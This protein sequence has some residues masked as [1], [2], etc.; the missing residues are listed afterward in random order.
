MRCFQAVFR[1]FREFP[2]FFRAFFDVFIITFKYQ[3]YVVCHM[4]SC[5]CLTLTTTVGKGIITYQTK[6]KR[7]FMFLGIE[8][9]YIIIVYLL[10][11][12]GALWCF[13]YGLKHWN[14]TD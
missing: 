8:D 1:P 4:L 14:D 5:Y 12:F 11:F 7:H 13:L 6:K 2:V 9:P 10:C 3:N